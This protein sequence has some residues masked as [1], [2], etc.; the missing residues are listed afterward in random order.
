MLRVKGFRMEV[1]DKSFA[2][3]EDEATLASDQGAALASKTDGE[4]G[5]FH[6]S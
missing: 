4:E 1:T 2:G 6:S 3:A 5:I